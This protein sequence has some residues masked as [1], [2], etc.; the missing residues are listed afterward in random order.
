MR[1]KLSRSRVASTTRRVIG[2]RCG[3]PTEGEFDGFGRPARFRQRRVD[4]AVRAIL[5]RGQLHA[6]AADI[7]TDHAAD[8][9]EIFARLLEFRL[10]ACDV[11]GKVVVDHQRYRGGDAEHGP[12]ERRRMLGLQAERDV[13][14]AQAL[15]QRARGG[16]RVDPCPRRRGVG[17]PVERAFDL[18]LD[19]VRAGRRIARRI[20]RRE[21]VERFQ[22][23]RIA[24]ETEHRRE[25]DLRLRARLISR[26]CVVVRPAGFDAQA[27]HVHSGDVSGLEPELARLHQA[28]V[29]RGILLSD[30][31]EVLRGGELEIRV[32]KRGALLPGHVREIEPGRRFGLARQGCAQVALATTLEELLDVD[33]AVGLRQTVA[34]RHGIGQ[35]RGHRR[36]GK[37][38]DPADLGGA[39]ID[40]AACHPNLAV[41]FQED[42]ARRGQRQLS[43]V[44]NDGD[45]G[46]GLGP[47]DRCREQACGADGLRPAAGF[48]SASNSRS[49]G[50]EPETHIPLRTDTARVSAG[51]GNGARSAARSERSPVLR[52]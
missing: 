1:T 42:P 48:Q 38:V 13:T 29:F 11:A 47:T 41:G 18:R 8:P 6:A 4:H 24:L 37:D 31:D 46:R 27:G 33:D 35:F 14:G 40:S 51:R 32:G 19:L 16:Q 39:N 10:G 9:L 5:R 28:P 43:R 34:A 36:V 52:L 15:R 21:I 20:E 7:G 30:L 49:H 45:G 12:T 17:S 22:R 50:P 2:Q 26:A 25:G 23:G 44:R 3:T